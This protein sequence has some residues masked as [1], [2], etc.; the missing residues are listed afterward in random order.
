MLILSTDPFPTN[1]VGFQ[2]QQQV[3]SSPLVNEPLLLDTS[4]SSPVS[5][6]DSKSFVKISIQPEKYQVVVSLYYF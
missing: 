6:S 3:D 5:S 2:Y 1:N 4:L